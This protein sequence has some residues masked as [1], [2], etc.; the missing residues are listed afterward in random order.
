MADRNL[1][2]E[3]SQGCDESGTRISMYQDHIRLL[4]LQNFLNPIQHT[5]RNIKQRLP[6]LHNV[7]II[8]RD[9]AEGTEDLIQHL[10]MLGGYIS[11][12]RG[13]ILIASGRVPNTHMIR[14]FAIVFILLT[15][16]FP[17]CKPELF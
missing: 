8:V 2:V 12:T 11:K 16:C 14:F 1:E 6:I 4:F 5:S 15:F 7:Q 10:T 13:Q 3:A 9:Y 17:G